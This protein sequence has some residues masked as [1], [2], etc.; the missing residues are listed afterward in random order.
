MHIPIKFLLNHKKGMCQNMVS[1]IL[2]L[3][4]NDLGSVKNSILTRPLMNVILCFIP[5]STA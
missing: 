2:Y 1:V 4:R 3:Q 5:Y